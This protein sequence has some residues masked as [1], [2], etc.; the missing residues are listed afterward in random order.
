MDLIFAHYRNRFC[1]YRTYYA[2]AVP[3]G[4]VNYH[5][6]DRV[7]RPAEPRLGR[8]ARSVTKFRWRIFVSRIL[9]RKLEAAPIVGACAEWK[10]TMKGL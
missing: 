2:L 7:V 10:S 6:R 3:R 4:C 8:G 9:R 1:M 5:R